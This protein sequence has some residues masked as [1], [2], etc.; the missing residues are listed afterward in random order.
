MHRRLLQLQRTARALQERSSELVRRTFSERPRALVAAI[1]VLAMAMFF[2]GGFLAYLAYD[3]TT[4]LPDREAL[5]GLGDMVQST[6]IFDADDRPAFTIFKE[7]RIEIPLD[8]V[9]PNMINAV[10]SVEDQRF[11]DHAGI[12][13]VRVG[14]AVLRN[15]RAGRRAEGGSTITQQLARQ[16]F[17]TRGKTYRRKLKEVIVAAYL[18]KLYTK[19]E[20]LEM[21]LNKVYFGDGLYGVEAA[22]RGYFGKPAANLEVDEAALLAGLIQSP[23]SYAPS[24]NMDRAVARR[25]T[26]LQAMVSAGAL[27]A[28]AAERARTAPVKLVNALEIRETFGLYFKEQVRREIVERFGWQRVYQGG[29]RV[30]TTIESDLQ[31]A[32]EKM[33]EE[34][35][36]DIERRS[37]FKY[38][39]REAAVVAPVR[40]G[41]RQE[42][43]APDYLQGALIALDP[44]TGHVSV[45]VGG[46]DFNDSRFN[47][48]M[49]AKRQSGSAFKPFVYAAALEAGHSPASLITGLNDPIAT[50]Q[51]AWIPEDDHSTA[52]EMTMRAALR[53]SSNR[54]AVQM[55][56]T[57]TIPAAVSYAEKLNVGKPPSVPS[58][59]LGASDVTLSSL[60][61][62]YA[63]FANGGIVHTPVLIRR[64][65]DS[66]GKVLYQEA[67]K[68]HRA[69][70]EATAFLMSS[71]LSDVIN[72]GTAYR[73]RQS[74]FTLPAAGKTGTTNDYNDAWFVG[75]TPKVVTGVW[76]GFDR[77][78]TIASGGYA[79]ELAVPIWA[80]FMKRATRGH[81]PEWFDRPSNVIGLNVCR[82]SGQLPVGGCEHVQ[83]VNRE[84]FSESRSMVYTEYFVRGTQPQTECPLHGLSVGQRLASIFGKDVGTPVS[85]DDAGLPRAAASTTGG[86]AG[87]SA[88][89]SSAGASDEAP[90]K[91]GEK[92]EEPKKKRGFWSRIFGGGGDDK[93]KDEEK[94]REEERKKDEE[95]RT[96]Q[97]ERRRKGGT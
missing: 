89:A 36:Q 1:G 39:K 79:G 7:Q 83:V 17:L 29:L 12:D 38:A 45:M 35:L 50:V 43:D 58:L 2:S 55:L 18:E 26:V 78:K 46:R 5:R 57:V 61:A 19:Q 91:N 41:P 82:I 87:T 90:G 47:R 76:V 97:E 3:L 95:E 70:S 13:A 37:G 20:I 9:S 32:A 67:G 93:K 16:A 15:L 33:L 53:T 62:A 22:A 34:G 65:E 6:T 72:A 4:G 71:M 30:Y 66:E 28:A 27:D 24:V 73:A 21:Y 85:V 49:Q 69:V 42:P 94:K 11:F 31:Q 56:R 14:G 59:A 40:A 77:P 48:A 92:V 80:S 63:S 96:R 74:G 51:G 88:G 75:Y 86:P 23:S 81:K 44:A 64:V 8:K 10:I 52:D 84:G 54:A 60:T 25:G 68:S